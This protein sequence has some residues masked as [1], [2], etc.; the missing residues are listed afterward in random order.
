MGGI[1]SAGIAQRVWG[2]A[3][4]RLSRWKEAERHLAASI[5]ALL[6]DEYLLEAARTRVVWGLLCRE[7]GDTASA[8]GHLEQATAQFKASGLIRELETVNGYLAQMM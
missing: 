1:L 6:L 3:L 5:H 8:Q 7:R 2:Q 4:A